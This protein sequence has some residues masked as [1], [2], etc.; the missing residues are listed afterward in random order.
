MYQVV[1][2][3][4]SVG[5]LLQGY[6]LLRDALYFE[7][8]SI[9]CTARLIADGKVMGVS[10]TDGIDKLFLPDSMPCYDM[11][12]RSITQWYTSTV[13]GI[14]DYKTY[15]VVGCH[16][17]YKPIVDTILYDFA[18]G[19]CFSN[20]TATV[21][22]ITCVG[23]VPTI[24]I[25]PA[26]KVDDYYIIG[27]TV[28]GIGGSIEQ[29]TEI[30]T[31]SGISYIEYNVFMECTKLNKLTVS[32]GVQCIGAWAFCGCPI[33]QLS[34]PTTL[35]V[36]GEGAFESTLLTD[37]NIPTGVFHIGERA[38]ATQSL[39]SVVIPPSVSVIED[40]AFGYWYY[41]GID[42]PFSFNRVPGFT[43]Y[44]YRGTVAE[45]YALLNGFTFVAM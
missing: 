36:I 22:G 2:K 11:Q 44:G 31:P 25:A 12:G 41:S 23:A 33:T 18:D 14:Y 5:D 9:E 6:M 20:A 1:G 40:H 29:A 43:I 45:M 35:S 27:K 34:L 4:G 8:T 21:N 26:R 24:P 30:T 37:V 17:G 28:H 19:Y 38:F 32:D 7:P 13:V 39:R 3:I 42:E 16:P 10:S 15:L